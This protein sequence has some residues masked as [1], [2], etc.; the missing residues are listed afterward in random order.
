MSLRG[1]LNLDTGL[2][3]TLHALKVLLALIVNWVVLT[4]FSADQ[5]VTWAVTSSV[6]IV[7]TASD[8]G[9]GQ[10]TVTRLINSKSPEWPALIGDGISALLPLALAGGLFVFLAIE[11][12]SEPYRF[13]MAAMLTI[14]ILSIPFGALLNAVNQY[15]IR[16]AIDLFSYGLAA[17]GIVIIARTEQDIELVLLTLNGT[18]VV[19]ALLTVILS[20][21]FC[22]VRD[23]LSSTSFIPSLKVLSG[24][25]PFMANNLTTLLTY[26]GFI[27]LCSLALPKGEIAKVAVLH[28]FV[29]MNLYQLYDVFLKARQ[30]DL[31]DPGKAE[32][33]AKAST[34]II[35]LSFVLFVIAGRDALELIGN[36]VEIDMPTTVLFGLFMASELGNLYA[37]SIAQV[38]LTLVGHLKTYSFIRLSA[39]IGFPISM[40]LPADGQQKL[41]ALLS[42]VSVFSISALLFLIKKQRSVKIYDE[43]TR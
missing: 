41:L 1:L 11:G 38:R 23:S 7:A 17:I 28:S 18:F 31:A 40:S 42:T 35:I 22:S 20:A 10:Y 24:A 3:V 33:Y 21:R 14:R 29:L 13:A 12:G 37:Q 39:V 15:K 27:W 34:I 5:F 32:P 8:L 30:A 43:L 19:G 2:S 9:I 25:I 4:H 16:K 6:L 26:G 36:P